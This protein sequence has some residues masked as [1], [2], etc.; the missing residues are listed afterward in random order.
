MT[1]SLEDFRKHIGYTDKQL[2]DAAKRD[3]VAYTDD[4]DIEV[5]D[6]RQIEQ[7]EN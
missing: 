5:E 3:V 2:R 4:D 6:D 7:E 1:I